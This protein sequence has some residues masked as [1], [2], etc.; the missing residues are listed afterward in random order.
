ME[1]L[2][3]SYIENRGNLKF[4]IK[5]LPIEAQFSRVSAILYNDYDS[6]GNKDVLLAGNFF[7]NR[8]QYGIADASHGLLLKGNS[9]GIFSAL[10]PRET[11]LYTSGNIRS[12]I[13]LKTKK[14]NLII[15]GKNS[16]LLQVI[17]VTQHKDDSL[18]SN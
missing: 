7:E 13:E 15:I 11:G 17:K 9:K 18:T 5:P 12:M 8:V 14:T 4:T 1:T 10:M 16:D 6:D 2:Q 3:T